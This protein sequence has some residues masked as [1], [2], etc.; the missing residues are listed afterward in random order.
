M[1]KNL[2]A[3]RWGGKLINFGLLAGTESTI[4][5]VFL[6]FRGQYQI[7]GS[8][9]GSLGELEEGLGMVRAG[10]I[11]PVLDEILPLGDVVKAHRRIDA[12]QVAG[13]LVL[14]PWA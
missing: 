6:F 1:Q 9:M 11:K 5:N 13:N 8:F 4:P 2:E 3:L 10:K 12:H 14:D 7:L